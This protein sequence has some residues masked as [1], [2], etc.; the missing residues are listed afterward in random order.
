MPIKR[1]LFPKLP[2]PALPQDIV[3][4]CAT[5]GQIYWRRIQWFRSEEY[6]AGKAEARERQDHPAQPETA[7]VVPVPS[8]QPPQE[9]QAPLVPGSPEAILAMTSAGNA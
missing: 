9:P 1:R 4:A 3:V 2:I 6:K 5:I 7:P 8:Q